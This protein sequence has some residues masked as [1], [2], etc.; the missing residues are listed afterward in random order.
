MSTKEIGKMTR[1]QV[2]E[3]TL[4]ITGPN[5]KGSGLMITSTEK[6][7]KHGWMEASIRAVTLRARKT[8]KVN[9]HGKMVL[10]IKVIGKTTKSMVLVSIFGQTE[11]NTK[12][13]GLTIKC[14]GKES[15]AGVTDV[16]T[17]EII[18]MIKSMALGLTPG[19][20]DASI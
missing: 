11:G 7:S 12:D 14:T 2:R 6:E 4:T 15:I 20:M 8:E 16:V 10:I 3:F 5:M 17:K 19:R 1:L 18:S 13:N 9:I